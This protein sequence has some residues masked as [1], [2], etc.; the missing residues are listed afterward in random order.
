M[1]TSENPPAVVQLLT[2]SEVA[3]R[4]G[5]S[6]AH[7]YELVMSEAI[8]SVKIGRCRRVSTEALA[9]RDFQEW[10]AIDVPEV[11]VPYAHALDG[12]T[13]DTATR[14]TRDFEQLLGL[15]RAH[16]L[17]HR[18]SRLSDVRGRL[19]AE[20]ADYEAVRPLVATTLAVALGEAVAP[21]VRQVVDVVSS[22][23]SRGTGAAFT[24]VA[25]VAAALDI[26]HKAALLRVTDALRLGYLVDN[27]PRDKGPHELSVGDPMPA[28][29]PVLPSVDELRQELNRWE[30]LLSQEDEL[31][32]RPVRVSSRALRRSPR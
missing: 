13:P 1:N 18:H 27:R 7:T 3:G 32:L 19:L 21:P 4:L 25:Q 26:D 30:E 31:P 5:I 17:L 24:R 6:R 15:I 10:L 8:A 29:T 2:V 22:L 9:T 11:V 23:G 28:D 14:Q 16:A 20:L 12:L